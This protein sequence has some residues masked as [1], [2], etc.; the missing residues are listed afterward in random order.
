[1]NWPTAFRTLALISI[2]FTSACGQA[3]ISPARHDY[4]LDKP[5]GWI[6]FSVRIPQDMIVHA[7][8]EPT[9]HLELKING[10]SF[11]SESLPE[12]GGAGIETGYLFAVPAGHLE[13]APTL[14]G[15]NKA[16]TTDPTKV[17]SAEGQRIKLSYDGAG[18]RQVGAEPYTPASLDE[19]K[20][21]MQRS[22]DEAVERQILQDKQ[23]GQLRLLVWVLC[24]LTACGVI[25]S[26]VR[27]RR[28]QTN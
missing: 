18:I 12:H 16:T 23:I 15:C 3:D 22:N 17:D 4:I 6:E 25:A 19:L 21:T 26:L 1:M 2:L 27:S 10:E 5:H 7:K 20:Q 11:L 9:C 13:L 8:N 24:A 28:K 14:I